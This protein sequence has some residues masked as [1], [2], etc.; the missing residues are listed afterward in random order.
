MSRTH[1][2]TMHIRLAFECVKSNKIQTDSEPH[3]TPIWHRQLYASKYGL[4][5]SIFAEI[6]GGGVKMQILVKTKFSFWFN[7]WLKFDEFRRSG[8]R[9]YSVCHIKPS[10]LMQ[11]VG[12]FMQHHQCRNHLQS[13]KTEIDV[14]SCVVRHD[15]C[16][17][18]FWKR[19]S[20]R[21]HM[22]FVAQ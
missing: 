4:S 6:C 20:K 10:R 8:C 15:F 14:V 2:I 3:T 7:F 16:I 22:V 5:G 1:S 19:F 13:I 9:I 21:V 11:H 17:L 12:Q 18:D